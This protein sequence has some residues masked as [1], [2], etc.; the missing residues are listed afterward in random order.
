MYDVDYFIKKFEAIPVEKW[1]DN[2]CFRKGDCFCALGHCGWTD[3]SDG[4]KITAEGCELVELFNKYGFDVAS[5][6]DKGVGNNPKERILSVLKYIKER[7]NEAKECAKRM[8]D[9]SS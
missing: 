7:Q 9:D 6:N 3:F 8:R 1:N 2:G 4:D 5:V